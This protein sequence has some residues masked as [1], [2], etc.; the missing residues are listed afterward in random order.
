MRIRDL[1]VLSSVTLVA[2]GVI[3]NAQ[4]DPTTALNS[5]AHIDL[6]ISPGGDVFAVDSQTRD[7]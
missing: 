3:G 7:V 6:E 5:S 4:S 1:I 2:A